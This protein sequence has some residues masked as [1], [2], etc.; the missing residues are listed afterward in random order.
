MRHAEL[1]VLTTGVVSSSR[2]AVLAGVDGEDPQAAFGEY[3]SL[4]TSGLFRS[5]PGS[6]QA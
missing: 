1:L 5:A 6:A 4:F 3:L 2:L